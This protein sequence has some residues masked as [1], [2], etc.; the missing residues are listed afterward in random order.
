MAMD[1][2]LQLASIVEYTAMT[3]SAR[4]Q[5]ANAVVSKEGRGHHGRK[6]EIPVVA[7]LLVAVLKVSVL[8]HH[9]YKKMS[10]RKF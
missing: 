3:R 9:Q 2:E 1:L 10:G 6:P 5:T 7:W 4:S 8:C